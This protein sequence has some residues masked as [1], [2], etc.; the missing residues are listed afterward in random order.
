MIT[1]REIAK[2]CNVSI[3][4]VSNILNGKPKASEE[5]R[6]RVMRVMEERGYHPNYI[7]QG[8]RRQKTRMIGI[9]AE[10]IAQFT[11]PEIIDGIMEHCEKRNY[12]TVVQNLRLYSRWQDTWYSDEKRYRSALDPALRELRSI[13]VDGVIYVA[14]HARILHCFPDDF[15]VPAVMAYAYYDTDEM[16]SFV[17]DDE[18]GAYEMTR[19]LFSMGHR[20]IGFVGGLEDNIHAQKRLRGIQ[21]AYCDEKLPFLSSLVCFGGWNREDGYREAGKVISQGVTAVFCM[22]DRIAGGVY[23]YMGERHL[24]VGRDISVS[25]FDNQ[26]IAAYFKPALTTMELPLK[27]IGQRSAKALLDRL[28]ADSEWDVKGEI[29]IPCRLVIRESVRKIE[30]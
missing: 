30:P 6:Q 9:I 2:E 7:A 26:N 25:G 27:E 19:Y 21:R 13:R 8:L 28:E 15:P 23:D 24:A 4:T 1:I 16:P 18:Q 10:D 11:M 5:T 12:R 20:R 14:G 17:L 29:G 22:A 3:T